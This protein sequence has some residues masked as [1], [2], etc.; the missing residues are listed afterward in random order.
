MSDEPNV[1]IQPGAT[2]GDFVPNG[3]NPN[4]PIVYPGWPDLP[5][6][7][8]P[9]FVDAK[10]ITIVFG[11]SA[12]GDDSIGGPLFRVWGGENAWDIGRYWT[13]APP[14][15]QDEFYGK[16][17]VEAVWNS[18]LYV[19]T[20]QNAGSAPLP[21]KAWSGVVARQPALARDSQGQWGFIDKHYLRGGA[22]Q[23]YLPDGSLPYIREENTA[24]NLSSP[25]TT[26][27]DTP[28]IQPLSVEM[29]PEGMEADY[30][31]LCSA[32][33]SLSNRLGS[34]AVQANGSGRRVAAS[35][36]LDGPAE[37]LNERLKSLNEDLK[38]VKTDPDA[39]AHARLI[40]WSLVAT[41]RY[42]DGDFSWSGQSAAVDQAVREIVQAA[43]NLATAQILAQA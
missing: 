36:L 27:V 26:E 28:T 8:A 4:G 13:L 11:G 20:L 33:N 5:Q 37:V 25:R 14:A 19:A 3:L 2:T 7:Q 1:I 23:V 21:I 9:N 40:L 35:G 22:I 10:P 18:G 34:L 15:T 6:E 17:A 43:Y 24:W 32:I 38:K 41:G 39:R 29:I 42:L 31:R 30:Q 12:S 16:A